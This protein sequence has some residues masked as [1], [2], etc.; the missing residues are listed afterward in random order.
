MGVQRE[1]EEGTI[2]VRNMNEYQREHHR[3]KNV[4]GVNKYNCGEE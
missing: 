2:A 4:W 3:K 1:K